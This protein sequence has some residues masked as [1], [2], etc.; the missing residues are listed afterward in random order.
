MVSPLAAIT[1]TAVAALK[2]YTYTFVGFRLLDL[3]DIKIE[4]QESKKRELLSR[5][6]HEQYAHISA[7]IVKR[8]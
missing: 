2:S 3:R 5:Y 8:E 6:I 4:S 1:A 7:K